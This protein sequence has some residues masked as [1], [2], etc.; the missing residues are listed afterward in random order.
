MPMCEESAKW[1]AMS[2]PYR[3]E[4]K[5]ARMLDELHAEYFIPMHYVLVQR[6]AC[7]RR[8]L[9]PAVSN[10]LFVH[11]TETRMT[12]LKG[13][14]PVMQYKV[15]KGHTADGKAEKNEKIVIR[16]EEMDA[17]I[18]VCKE[19]LERLQFLRPEE[20]NLE[21]GTKVRVIGGPFDGIEGTFVKV[22]GS[23][24]RKLVI[25]IDNF[26]SVATEVSPEM[27]EVLG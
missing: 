27:I 18:K 23:R 4:M 16:D 26:V 11:A 13:K 8:Q 12:Y 25:S 24:A 22:K 14:V 19:E 1:F 17:F 6:G 2:A 20:V 5:A 21:K 15:L 10:L 7:K 3:N 9:V